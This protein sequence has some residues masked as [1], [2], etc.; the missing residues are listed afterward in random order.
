[1]E[2]R[3]LYT[4]LEDRTLM[5]VAPVDPAAAAPPP[6]NPDAAETTTEPESSAGDSQPVG[7]DAGPTAANA[8]HDVAF[9][10][11]SAE[12]YDQLLALLSEKAASDPSFTLVLLDDQTDGIAAVSET[13]SSMSGVSNVHFLTADSDD[14]MLKL[15]GT[16]LSSDMLSNRA[17]EIAGWHD[18]LR[19][20]GNLMFYGFDIGASQE[21]ADLLAG[22]AALTGDG[23]IAGGTTMSADDS[24][25]VRTVDVVL[26]DR[27]LDDVNTLLNAVM[28]GD[29]VFLYDGT[30]ESAT[31]V[32]GDVAEWAEATH[33]RIGTFTILSHGSPGSFALGSQMIDVAGL[34]AGADSW[35]TLSGFFTEHAV[36]DLYGCYVADPSGNGS[37][38]VD[39]LATLTGAQVFASSDATG[40]GGDWVL[41]IGAFGATRNSAGTST[42]LDTATLERYGSTLI[43]TSQGSETRAN[44]TTSGTQ[45]TNDGVPPR[46]VAMDS[47]GNY[48]V[49]WNGSGSGDTDGIFA[50]RYNASGVAQGSEWRVNTTTT[51]PQSQANVAM[52]DAGNFVITWSN[53]PNGA[54]AAVRA[55]RY[56]ASGVA[57]GGEIAVNTTTT[58]AQGNPVIA[59][60]SSGFVIAWGDSGADGS[61]YGVYAQRFNSSGTKVGSEFRVNSTTTGDQWVDSV[62]MDDSGNFI[63]TWSSVDQDGD[64]LGVY[65]KR[66]NS[67]GTVLTSETRVNTNTTGDQDRSNVAMNSSGE[68][69]ITWTD[70][71]ADGSGQGIY[72]Q[73]Y[74]SSAVAQGFNFNVNTTTSGNQYLS[75]AGMD[76]EGNFVITWSSYGQDASSTWGMYKQEYYADGIATGGEVRVNTTTSSNQTDGGVAMNGDGRFV[77]AWSG[78][79]TGD[80]SGVFFQRYNTVSTAPTNNVPA[81]QTTNED[82]TL[83]FNSANGNLISITDADAG[84]NSLQVTLTVTSGALT[85]SG[86]TGLTFTAGDGT[87]DATMTFRG[88]LTNINNALNGMSFVPASNANGSVTLTMSTTDADVVTLNLDSSLKGFYTFESTGSLGNDFSPAG[89]YDGTVTGATANSDSQRGNVLNFSA[90]NSIQTTGHW[91]NPTNVTLAA[92][93]NLT[94]KDSSGSDIISLG[95][96]LAVR[97][98]G[99]GGVEAFYYNGSTWTT[100]QSGIYIEDTGWHHIAYTFDDTNNVHTLYI[101]GVNVASATT[102]SSISYTLGANSFIGKHGNGNTAMDFTGKMDDVRI[103]SRALSATEIGKIGANLDLV[104]TDTVAITVN[105]TNDVPVR[106]AGSPAAVSVN[107]DSANATAVSLGMSALTYGVGG[108]SDESAQTLTYKVTVIPSHMTLWLADGTTQVTANT[109]LTL[110]QLQGPQLHRRTVVL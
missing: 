11:A 98:D 91:G 100:I 29:Q 58:G 17:G 97:A 34:E 56:N 32:L 20:D 70:S 73:R 78:N 44:T 88:T 2:R 25:D 95:D 33:A 22:I 90:G 27:T 35:R 18:A 103:Y 82:T 108:G 21:G 45:Q 47:S 43:S 14:G 110:A 61:S 23:V 52:D 46:V 41:E 80:T 37:V 38:L 7:G 54:N 16:W 68:F 101:D 107:E 76:D 24:A 26:I 57:Q 39:Q 79:G 55:Q 5:S 51:D 96:S 69:V 109:T 102:S 104:S 87:G 77:V 6:E 86:I 19:S 53:D 84:S 81:A 65:F 105:A 12:N 59:M 15:G 36:I 48:V 42:S 66:Y 92:W 106:T 93:V 31:D 67:S 94:T 3:L 63:V 71:A 85:L 83:V 75:T 40:A 99:S 10:D 30:D 60:Y 4:Q 64:G 89:S 13:L 9:L 74:N 1:M 28:D 8:R 49:V 72:A 62:A 50:Q